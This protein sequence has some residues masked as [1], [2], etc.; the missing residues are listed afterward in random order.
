MVKSKSNYAVD[1]AENSNRL[2]PIY[3]MNDFAQTSI[4]FNMSLIE[5]LLFNRTYFVNI[6]KMC[7]ASKLLFQ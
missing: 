7:N 1:A 2:F 6:W 5:H 4:L 3:L